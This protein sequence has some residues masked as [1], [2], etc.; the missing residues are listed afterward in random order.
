MTVDLPTLPAGATAGH[1][2]STLRAAADLAACDRDAWI[3][4]NSAYYDDDVRYMRFLIP[5]GARVL[6]LGCGTGRL[7]A[8]L[9]PS[10]GVGVDISQGMVEV[11]RKNHPDLEF[12]V[13]DVEDPTFLATIQGP[14]DYI[15]LSDTLGYADDCVR[16]MESLHRFCLPSTRIIIASYSHLW[17]PVLRFAKS[18]GR[19]M[20]THDH[21]INWLAIHDMAN[22]LKITD[23][24]VVK[25]EWRQLVPARMMGVGTFINK[26]IA[27]LPLIRTLC[28]RR[29]V[30]ARPMRGVDMG[31][32]SCTVVVPCRNERGNI[33]NA[34][35]RTPRFCDDMEILFVE[36]HSSDGTWEEVLR[37]Q[38]A[39]PHLDIKAVRQTGKGKGN[40]VREAFDAARGDVL[41][42]LDADLTMPPEELPIYYQL[43]ASGKAE[44][45]NGTRFVYTMEDEA[46]RFL[47]YWA[48][49]AFALIFS[50][51]LGWTFTDT[52]CGTKVLTRDCYRKIADG[53]HFF[54]DFDPFGDFD[55]IFG[56]SKN[57]MALVEVPIRYAARTYGTTQI[58]RFRHGWLLLKMVVFAFRK[59]KML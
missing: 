59:L 18:I 53:R 15:V 50:Y 19:R 7:L 10:L 20:P 25:T 35:L 26:V 55:L 9:K 8:A 41:M 45:V 36:G 56:A 42:I 5:E 16:L 27:P 39:Y 29:Y 32:P 23:F 17:E 4:R 40:A 13:G 33:E 54:G 12:L 6:D 43:L 52:L 1:R 22:I 28:L 34:V 46:M 47:N 37:V 30:V 49:R 31:N 24:E 44:F 3:D 11:A 14:F 21:L 2:K 48:N 51:L 38:Q 57:N 58:S